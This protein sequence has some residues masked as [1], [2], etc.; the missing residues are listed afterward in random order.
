MAREVLRPHDVP[1]VTPSVIERESDHVA[2][3]LESRPAV[4]VNPVN[5]ATARC[6]LRPSVKVTERESAV[7]S[8]IPAEAVY[9]SPLV[10]VT[11]GGV[12]GSVTASRLDSAGRHPP[13]RLAAP[14]GVPKAARLDRP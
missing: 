8:A 4:L 14:P 2:D 7:E 9:E 11:D 12:A 6:L 13:A 3:E 10:S 5:G 1:A